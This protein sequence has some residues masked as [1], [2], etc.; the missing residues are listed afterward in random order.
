M[1]Q[2][3]KGII[4]IIASA[5]FF[6]LMSL[7][8]KLSGDLPSIQKS[9]FRNFVAA[10][11]ATVI[12]LRSGKGFSFE[13]R[14]LPYL[15]IRSVFGTLGILCNFYAVDHLLLSDASM[16]NKMSPFFA[17]LCS[18]FFLR[19]KTRPYQ[20]GAVLAAFAGALFIIRPTFS[21][22]ELL[23]S[24]IGLLGGFAAGAAYTAV[25]FLG[26]RGERGPFVVFFFS[27]FSC[28]F[29]LPFMIAD[30][31]PMSLYQL[32]MLLLAG[33]AAA[34][35]QFTITFAYFYAPAGEIS[36]YDYTQ[37]L[38]ATLWSLVIFSQVPDLFSILGYLI[39][40]TAAVVNF[41]LAQRQTRRK[42]NS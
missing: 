19:E 13:K 38:F 7:F 1:K 31:A 39:I 20:I 21:N 6:S 37:I 9:F 2:Q 25:R 34:G 36:I 16:L 11:F 22:L 8:V 24:L 32:T 17:I 41:L 3:Y 15:I 29:C 30:Y 35:G 33:F 18:M 40:C 14:N 4:L 42:K 5:F 12:L 26:Q 10:I 28:L 23:P 27:A